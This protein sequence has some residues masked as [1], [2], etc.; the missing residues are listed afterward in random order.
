MIEL[1]NVYKKLGNK[2]VLRGVDL[3]IEPEETMVIIGGSGEGKSVLLKHMIGLMHPDRGEVFID[4][5]NITQIPAS[6]LN[7]VRSKFGMLFQYAALFDSM[8]VKENVGFA[9]YEHTDLPELEICRIVK[10][11][12]ALVH[13]SGIE[14]M[15]PSELS[16]GMKKRVGLARALAREPKII[17]YDEPTTGLD[18]I[19]AD[20]IN[21]LII[22][23]K[24]RLKV[25]A[26]VVT[27]DMKS[28]FK[29]ADRIAMLYQ[30]KI[31]ALGAVKEFENPTDPVVHQFVFGEATGPITEP[32]P[33]QG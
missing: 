23:L 33:S 11:K 20:M 16:G 15:M 6:E 5:E 30:G 14:S 1:R 29:I 26:V 18:P 28:A 27:H 22:E 4:G 13:L 2:E 21:L 12:L 3:K 25:T 10:E 19:H 24:E 8:N 31:I 9:L 7:R 17:L 32:L